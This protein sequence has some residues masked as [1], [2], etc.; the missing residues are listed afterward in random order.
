VAVSCV[1]NIWSCVI[2]IWSSGE[3]TT[4]VSGR[5]HS[6]P[7]GWSKPK[8]QSLLRTSS[9]FFSPLFLRFAFHLFN[10]CFQTERGESLIHLAVLADNRMAINFLLEGGHY[11]NVFNEKVFVID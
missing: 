10:F 8:P 1:I 3:N 4:V 7:S 11:L 5:C 2:D 9:H 6:A